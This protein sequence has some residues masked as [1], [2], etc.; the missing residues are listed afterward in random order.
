MTT[1]TTFKLTFLSQKTIPFHKIGS[2]IAL[3]F[4]EIDHW[5]N[6][7]MVAMRCQRGNYMYCGFLNSEIVGL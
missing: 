5:N 4:I 7:S 1:P 2:K 3:F 6:G